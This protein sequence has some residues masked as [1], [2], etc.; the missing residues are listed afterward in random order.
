MFP[1]LLVRAGPKNSYP[2]SFK[3]GDDSLS[4]I[5][6]YPGFFLKAGHPWTGV[7]HYAI[8]T[9]MPS[10]DNLRQML[11]LTKNPTFT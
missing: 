7:D 5:D 9:Q 11:K 6:D 1:K 3:S 4:L 8:S 10:R 2:K